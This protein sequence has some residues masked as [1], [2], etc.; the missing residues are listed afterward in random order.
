MLCD[1]FYR[2]DPFFPC[3]IKLSLLYMEVPT[4][5]YE[6]ASFNLGVIGLEAF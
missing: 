5:T 3:S 4:E 1:T 2:L 6:D